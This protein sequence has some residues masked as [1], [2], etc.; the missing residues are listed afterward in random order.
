[1]S[2]VAY[3][4]PIPVEASITKVLEDDKSSFVTEEQPTQEEKPSIQEELAEEQQPIYQHAWFLR[5]SVSTV[6][7]RSGVSAGYN[8]SKRP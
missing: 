5:L 2:H 4:T 3:P 7:N 6:S 1:M 8:S